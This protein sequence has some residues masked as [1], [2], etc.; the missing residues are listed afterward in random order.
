MK[1]D[2]LRRARHEFVAHG[3]MKT[4]ESNHDKQQ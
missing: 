3:I 2:L 1:T 4:G